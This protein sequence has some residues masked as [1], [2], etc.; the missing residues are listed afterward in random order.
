MLNNSFWVPF[1]Q[2]FTMLNAFLCFL[3]RAKLKYVWKQRKLLVIKISSKIREITA[4]I[5][6]KSLILIR[7]KLQTDYLHIAK[8]I[9]ADSLKTIR[10]HENITILRGVTRRSHTHANPVRMRTTQVSANVPKNHSANV[11]KRDVP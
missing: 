3:V 11:C 10:R 4:K 1:E 8:L 5:T 7:M 6:N 9:G 2:W